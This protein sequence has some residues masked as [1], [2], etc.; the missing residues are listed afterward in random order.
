MQNDQ[1][2]F[3][4]RLSQLKLGTW[5][6]KVSKVA[7][8]QWSDALPAKVASQLM[9]LNQLGQGWEGTVFLVRDTQTGELNALKIFD[10]P[11]PGVW[12]TGLE[13]Y[14]LG[15]PDGDCPGLFPIDLIK[16]SG[17]II[18]SVYPYRHLHKLNRRLV[19][20]VDQ[21]GQA[22]LSSYCQMQRYLM[23]QH[24]LALW[25]V[26][27]DNF[28]LDTHGQF[29]FFDF[30]RGV[31]AL[32]NPVCADRGLFE[33]G[34]VMLLLSIYDINVRVLRPHAAGYSDGA[35][36]RYSMQLANLPSH[37]DWVKPITRQLRAAQPSD[38]LNPQFY[39]EIGSTL[40]RRVAYPG[41]LIP[42][43]QV[44]SSLARVRIRLRQVLSR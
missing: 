44:I 39:R 13:A 36:Y 24:N 12:H 5:R 32:D 23:T 4:M 1:N 38:F 25:D 21:I 37:R 18:G 8:G 35:S 3:T 30:G 42:A 6:R 15:V 14:A 20:S 28:G 10:P 41:L 17:K 16:D 31:A 43:S 9:P 34:F 26:S 33:Y 29:W 22:L 19:W 27:T 2:R 40:P 11:I 7:W